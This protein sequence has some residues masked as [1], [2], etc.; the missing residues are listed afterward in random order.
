MGI[1]SSLG[2]SRGFF[3]SRI[4]EVVFGEY[5]IHVGNNVHVSRE[6]LILAKFILSKFYP[7]EI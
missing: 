1:F 3:I 7:G 6:N 5:L 2:F 4:Q